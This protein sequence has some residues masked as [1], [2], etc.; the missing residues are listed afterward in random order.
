MSSVLAAAVLGAYDGEFVVVGGCA[1]VL[2]GAQT[3][4][5]DLDVVPRPG[6]T[7]RLIDALT[8]LGVGECPSTRVL[9][10]RDV[11]G[12]DSPFGHI[13]VMMRRAREEYDELLERSSVSEVDGIEVRVASVP[14]VMRLRRQFKGAA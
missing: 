2:H 14:D 12:F 1:L 6:T 13:D 8:R 11:C 9:E 3:T 7:Q 10:A 5:G 4:C